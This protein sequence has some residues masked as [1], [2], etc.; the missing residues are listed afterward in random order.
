MVCTS[1]LVKAWLLL[2]LT[3]TLILTQTLALVISLL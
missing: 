1:Y 2:S 3:H